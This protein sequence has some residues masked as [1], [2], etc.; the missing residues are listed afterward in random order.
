MQEQMAVGP[1]VAKYPSAVGTNVHDRRSGPTVHEMEKIL[2]WCR[3]HV[4]I[5]FPGAG[6]D[7]WYNAELKSAMAGSGLAYLRL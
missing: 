7:V 4:R 1:N 5:V 2:E 3:S 6:A